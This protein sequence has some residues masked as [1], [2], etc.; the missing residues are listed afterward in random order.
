[1]LGQLNIHTEF[2]P[3]KDV[4]V[5]AAHP[6]KSFDYIADPEHRSGLQRILEETEEDLLAL[7]KIFA[8]LGVNVRR[9]TRHFPVGENNQ[10]KIYDLGLFRYTFPNHPLMPRDTTVVLGNKLI[11]TYTK[12]HGRFSENW[13]YYEHFM[14]FFK[15]GADWISMPPPILDA[16]PPAYAGFDDKMLL[17]HAANFLKCGKDLFV[18]QPSVGQWTEK[19]KGT[20]SGLE[21]FRRVIGPE[22]RVNMAPAAGHLDGKIALLRPGLLATW[23]KEYI[24]EKL[25]NWDVVVIEDT[26]PPFPEHFKKIKKQRFYH[27]FVTQWL[28]D[29]IGYVDETIFDVN[30]LSVSEKLVITN[31]YNKRVYAAFNSHGVEAIP[32]NFRHQYFWDGAIHCVTL[33]LN[34][35]GAREDYFS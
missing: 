32:W 17:F 16:N 30:M 29:W 12:S 18:S 34:R 2:Q 3:L 5:G 14:E 1:M 15:N 35:E 9:P 31:G 13:A 28:N 24:P 22:Y 10:P 25:K 4:L 21:W 20:E 8:D 26:P 11:Q 19:G 6:P 7:C 23:G 27:D 33:D